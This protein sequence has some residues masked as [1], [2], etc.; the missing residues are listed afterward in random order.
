MLS[1]EKAKKIVNSVLPITKWL[2]EYN[3]SRDLLSDI[4]A[5]ITV[6]VVHLP[7]GIF[8]V[9]FLILAD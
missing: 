1:G 3:V 8:V 4:A 5:G 6:G 2:P 7:Q 9:T